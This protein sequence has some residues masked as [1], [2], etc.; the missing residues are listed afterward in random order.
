MKY[1]LFCLLLVSGFYNSAIGASPNTPYVLLISLDG[2]RYDYNEKF[3]PPFMQSFMANSARAKALIPVFPSKTYT[4]HWSIMTG[5]YAGKHGIV[6]NEFFDRTSQRFFS[7]STPVAQEAHWY[8]GSAIW[9]V[10]RQQ[11]VKTA[12]LFWPGDHVDQP[13]RRPDYSRPYKHNSPHS[14]SIDQIL[15]WF[16]LSEAERPHFVSLYFSDLDD[17]GHLYG[18]DAPEVRSAALRVDQTLATLWQQLNLLPFKVNVIIVS[19]HGMESIQNAE[20]LIV[21]NLLPANSKVKLV[22]DG[23]LTSIFT[24]DTAQKK[25]LLANLT[26]DKRF[27]VYDAANFPANLNLSNTPL[28]GDILLSANPGYY[29]VRYKWQESKKGGVHGYNPRTTPNMRGIF[30]AQGPDIRAV[31]LPEFENIHI[32]PFI[33]RLLRLKTAS[34]IDGDTKVLSAAL[35]EAVPSPE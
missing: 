20:K 14:E 25:A 22:D 12:S 33:L 18:P 13:E 10:A 5:M 27:T 34:A 15:T 6:G 35:K 4:N 19:D 2:Y 24:K 29:F 32:H 23:T 30:Y 16:K 28:L 8:R 21:E 7:I 26:T 3:K 17:A 11:Q 1:L 9:T 31:D